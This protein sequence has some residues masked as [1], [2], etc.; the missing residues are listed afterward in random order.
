MA[1]FSVI[2][3]SVPKVDAFEKVTGRGLF[4]AD[5]SFPNMLNGKILRSPYPHAKI[6]SIDISKAV[7]HPEVRAVVTGKDAPDE[8]ICV[9]QDRYVLARDVVRFVG[10]PVAA[11]AADTVEAAEE[12][13][14]LID[15][16]YE[17]LPAI[18]DPEEAMK[19]NP[20][21]VLHPKLPKYFSPQFQG[22]DPAKAPIHQF[23]DRP[24]IL[25]Y[26]KLRTGDTEKGFS[27][28]DLIVE[29]RY[30]RARIQHCPMEPAAAVV[31]PEPDGG[32]TLW[33]TTQTIY[34]ERE[35]VARLFKIPPAKIRAIALYQG[36]GFGSRVMATV[37]ST[38]IAVLLA[39]KARRPVKLVLTR[40]EVF[41]DGQSEI[42]QVIYIKDGVKKDG[43]LVARE[44]RIIMNCGAYSGLNIIGAYLTAYA[45]AGTYR[46]PNMKVDTYGVA[47]NEPMSGPYRGFAANPPEW[48]I[49]CHMD[50]V[51]EKLGLDPAEM[52]RKNVLK[53]GEIN[54]LGEPVTNIQ[55]E[56]S[57]NKVLD[58]MEWEKRERKE[59]GPWRKGK[60]LAFSNKYTQGAYGSVVIV[61]VHYDGTVEVRHSAA[62]L[63]QGCNTS[64][65][66]MAAEEF[67]T[68][69]NR[70]R[71]VYTDTAVTPYDF[72]TIANR[73]TWHTG[74]AL[75]LACKDAK[76][77]IFERASVLLRVPP[78]NLTMSDGVI[79]RKGTKMG[80]IK[81]A[82]LFTM[83]MGMYLPK[84]GEIIGRGAYHSPVVFQDPETGHSPRVAAFYSWGAC[85]VEVAV[86]GETGEVKV[87]RVAQCFDAG[88]PI[89]PKICEGQTEGGIAQGIGGALYE[90]MIVVNGVVVNPNYVDYWIPSI[91]EV[92]VLDMK[93]MLATTVPHQEGPFGAKGFS[94]GGM[95]PMP[96]AITNAIYDA[97]GVRMKELPITREKVLAALGKLG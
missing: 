52:R 47:T 59:E 3:K 46:V 12:A 90:E 18:F 58:S 36:G 16:E 91:M 75:L 29:E 5:M 97:I 19:P 9:L 27:E 48:A 66:Q 28:S 11:V 45:S 32:L 80:A 23:A 73:V 82:D 67:G 72:G 37:P 62:D 35:F 1:E 64:L 96:P 25:V 81:L 38:H 93:A 61:K 4:T 21:V 65:A 57:L 53:E 8:R 51:A 63:G 17:E 88:Q 74:N 83:P 70:V 95:I 42:P 76:R 43:T 30:T 39:L 84:E 71:V 24:N 44:V 6:I 26:S 2:G 10:E 69:V 33:A 55:V 14:D 20:S 60:G 50:L 34:W 56:D 92:P 86:N 54:A 49:E 78:E 41:V 7:S 87:L 85:T 15:V 22:F 79:H 68:S 31:R 40:D 89:N 77:Q 13:L 94:E